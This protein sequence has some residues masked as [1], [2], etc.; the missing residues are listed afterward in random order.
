MSRVFLAHETA[1]GRK[2]VIKV[3]PPELSAGLNI[4]RFRRE[5]SELLEASAGERDQAGIGDVAA[6]LL[7]R[8]GLNFGMRYDDGAEGVRVSDWGTAPSRAAGSNRRSPWR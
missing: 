1:L 4:D 8:E 6:D 3:L 2:V 7:E 5:M